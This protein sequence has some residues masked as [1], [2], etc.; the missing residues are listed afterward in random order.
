MLGDRTPGFEELRS[1]RYCTRV[2]NESM[3]L[4]PQPPVLIRWGC[5]LVWVGGCQWVG[6]RAGGW[7]GVCW[8]GW[9]CAG[10]GGRMPVGGWV[11]VCWCGWEGASGWV[12][13]RAGGW[14]LA[15][16]WLQY[17]LGWLQRLHLNFPSSTRARCLPRSA[18]RR[19]LE[20]DELG[21]YK[22]PKGSDIFIS[23]WNLH[24]WA[25]WVGGWADGQLQQAPLV[26]VACGP[27]AAGCCWPAR[28]WAGSRGGCPHTATHP[29]TSHF[30]SPCCRSPELWDEPNTF[31]PD[32]FPVYS[33]V[34]NETT[35]DFKY[36]PFGGGKRKCIGE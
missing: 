8:C 26:L 22:V 12:G 29:P 1:L 34:P 23:T 17:C 5:M 32:R 21:G 9:V 11:D 6:G 16:R 24:R 35:H 19:A 7:V 27:G 2:I 30:S 31:N 28:H 14:G 3:R 4:Y 20:D 15:L 36:L 18:C 25:G 33:P 13:G 10:V